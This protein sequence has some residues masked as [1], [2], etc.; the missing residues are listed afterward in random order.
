MEFS[1]K[2]GTGVRTVCDDQRMVRKF[3]SQLIEKVAQWLV[4][5]LPVAQK[6]YVRTAL[7]YTITTM[8]EHTN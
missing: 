1:K 4:I 7:S 2:F 8:H 5:T 3:A 6:K